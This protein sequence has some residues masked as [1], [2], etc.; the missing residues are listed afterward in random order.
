VD[1][2]ISLELGSGDVLSP[3]NISVAFDNFRLNSGRAR[4]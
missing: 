3:G 2:R 4:R 1:T